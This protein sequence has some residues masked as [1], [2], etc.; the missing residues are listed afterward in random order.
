MTDT[1]ILAGGKSSR[2][3]DNKLATM[4][5]G[6][7]LIYYVV[8]T[9]LEVSEKVIIVTGH[10]PMDYLSSYLSD[11]RIKIVH[12]NNYERGMFSSVQCGVASVDN[13]FFLIPGDYP[14]VK[15]DTLHQLLEGTKRIRV[16]VY[17]NRRGHPIFIAEE[18]IGPLLQEPPDSNLKVFRDRYLVE[19]I[20][21]EDKGIIIDVDNIDDFNQLPRER[22]NHK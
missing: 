1:I 17:N 13:D 14:L 9:F 19:Y 15:L 6:K 22:M 5:Q 10:Y 4:Y 21:V 2:F 7:P 11:S 8:K 18:L 3:I 16:P 20:P 12:N